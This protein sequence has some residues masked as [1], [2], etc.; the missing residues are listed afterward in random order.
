[1]KKKKHIRHVLVG[2]PSDPEEMAVSTARFNVVY[3]QQPLC[4]SSVMA[5][6]IHDFI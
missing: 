1:M 4:T 2:V 3:L 6:S 5:C